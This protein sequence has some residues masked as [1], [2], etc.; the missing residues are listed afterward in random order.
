[1]PARAGRRV[2]GGEGGC[3]GGV[4]KRREKEEVSVHQIRSAG[5]GSGGEKNGE[6]KQGGGTQ[7]IT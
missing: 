1:V 3:L 6:S 7:M 2:L 4:N 5:G